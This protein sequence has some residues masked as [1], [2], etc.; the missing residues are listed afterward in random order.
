MADEIDINIPFEAPPAPGAHIFHILNERII[1]GKPKEG[2][3]L[4]E[5]ALQKVFGTGRPPVREAFHR[6][7]TEYPGEITHR[8]GAS[9]RYIFSDGCDGGWRNQVNNATLI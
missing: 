7:G 1:T 9:A 2:S 4:N 6:L 5:P 8:G 3:R